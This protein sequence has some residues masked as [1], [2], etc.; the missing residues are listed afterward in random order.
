MHL[1]T[2][3]T[4]M[5]AAVWSRVAG[6]KCVSGGAVLHGYEARRLRGVTFPGLVECEGAVTPGLVY[7]NVSAEALARLDAYEDDFYG[8]VAVPVRLED[9][10]TLTAEVYLILPTHREAVLPEKWLPPA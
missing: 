8:R 5:D 9:G 10:S 4:L 6:E 1:F 3:G 7:W 2:Y